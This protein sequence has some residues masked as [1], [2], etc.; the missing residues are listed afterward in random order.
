MLTRLLTEP[1]RPERIRNYSRAPWLAVGTVCIGA[2]MGQLDA[3]IVTVA[4]PSL[5][6]DLHASLG[7]VEW[8]SLSYLL[9]LSAPWWRSDGSPTWSGANCCTPTVLPCSRW[10]PSAVD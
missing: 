10:L 2:F 6:A 9:C 4:L 5:R 3:S 1:A 7:A 8:V